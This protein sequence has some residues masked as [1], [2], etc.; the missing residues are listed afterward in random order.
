MPVPTATRRVFAGPVELAAH[1]W[2]GVGPPALL[3]HA[4]GFHGLVW[5]PVA[6]R[7]VASGRRVW[8]FD[9]RGHGDSG[10]SPSGYRWEEFADDVLAVVAD[11]ALTGE[12]DLLAAGHSKGGAA[13]LLAEQRAPATFP[14]L[15]CYEPIVI[16]TEKPLDPQPDFPLAVAARRRRAVWDSREEALASFGSKPPLDALHPDALRA[17]IEHG[18]RECP[19]ASFELKCRPVDEATVYAMQFG[20]RAYGRLGEI[21][22]PVLVAC[23]ERTDAIVPDVARMIAD[24]L[25]RGRLEVMPGLGHLGP[26]QDPDATVASLLAFA[27]ATA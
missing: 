16:P 27:A 21:R 19:E 2:G 9:F 26:L 24:R 1:D 13:L 10:A 11:L 8:S 7:L 20:H 22:C 4:T 25:S 14:R 23:G 17:Y 5:A 3:A 18:L 6:E 15:W 12:P